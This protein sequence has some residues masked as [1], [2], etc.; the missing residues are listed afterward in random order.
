MPGSAHCRVGPPAT[1][2]TTSSTPSPPWCRARS[3]R[4]DALRVARAYGGGGPAPV[5]SSVLLLGPIEAAIVNGALA[6][7]D[8]TDDNYSAG[9]AHPG[10]AVVPAALAAA[11]AFGAHGTRFLRAVT[12]GYDVGMRA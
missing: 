12:L 9:G 11:E 3:L 7:A 6:Q 1:P 5:A 10:C 4:P 2:S 8:E